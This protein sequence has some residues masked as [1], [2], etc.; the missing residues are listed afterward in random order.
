MEYSIFFESR[1]VETEAVN[2]VV[3]PN[4]SHFTEMMRRS[5]QMMR[6]RRGIERISLGPKAA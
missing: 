4:E 3:C 1:R 2:D 6:A 5:F